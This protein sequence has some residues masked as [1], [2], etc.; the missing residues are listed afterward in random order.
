MIEID[1]SRF[2][3]R[4]FEHQLEGIKA[5]VK[6][7]SFALFDEPGAGKSKQ[8]VDAACVL[9]EAGKIDTVVIVAPA[10]VRTVWVN[11]QIGEIKK[12]SWMPSVVYEYHAKVNQVWIDPAYKDAWKGNLRWIVTN[13]EFLRGPNRLK[14]LIESLSDFGNI[15]LV[16]D[17][18]AYVKSR[19]AQQSKAVAELRQH[20]DRCV[21]LNGTPVVNN[22]LD[23]WSQFNILDKSILGKKYKNYWVFRGSYAVMGGWKNKQVV[24][25]I[26]LEKL[27]KMLAPHVLRRLKKDC[28]D[29]PD[30]LYT[31]R[32]V[33]LS[34]ESWKRYQELKK[35]A[36]M[37]LGNGDQLLEPNAAVR[38]MRLAQVTSG[39]IGIGQMSVVPTNAQDEAYDPRNDRFVPVDTEDLSSEK[40]D[41]CVKYLT[42]E[43]Q[44]RYVIVW[45]RWRRERE[46][47]HELLKKVDCHSFQLYGGQKQNERECAVAAFSEARPIDAGKLCIL[48]AQPHA[49]GHGL[50][51]IMATEV[52]YLS[53]DFSLG[54][55][56]QS[57]DRCHRPGQVHPVLY[58]DVIAVGPN[59]QRTIDWTIYQ[60]LKNKQ[61]LAKMT[62]AAWRKELE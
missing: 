21:I 42:E 39:H 10:S 19:T 5:L 2:K 31:V 26:N 29:L 20:C 23:L 6:N 27:T 28:L 7:K 30:K 24:K 15:M 57:E 4:P 60:A 53:N 58:T 61:D 49:G 3:S 16:L 11:E 59:G 9:A 51:L 38:V 47:L 54:I 22:P 1:P 56:L 17:E 55:R 48:L 41:W 34:A 40:I 33:A 25:W 35:D 52:I 12:H 8:V 36:V 46:R 45:C 62:T 13:Y 14:E 37:S 18:S 44:A 32:E 43:C 50:N